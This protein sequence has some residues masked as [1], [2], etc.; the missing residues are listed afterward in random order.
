MAT[1]ASRAGQAPC[2]PSAGRT[3]V[4]ARRN[5]SLTGN[6]FNFRLYILAS[7]RDK[8]SK[9]P[10]HLRDRTQCVTFTEIRFALLGQTHFRPHQFDKT[11]DRLH[12]LPQIMAG[13]SEEKTALGHAGFNR[14]LLLTG[15][16]VG[17]PLSFLK[18]SA[19]DSLSSVAANQLP[20]APVQKL[21]AGYPRSCGSTLGKR[22]QKASGNWKN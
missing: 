15:Q 14:D 4:S 18:R 10:Q 5:N 16:F 20:T 1:L 9:V 17:K 22:N 6:H 13:G 12:G 19:S 3:P 21:P 2:V 11:G 7:S 8:S